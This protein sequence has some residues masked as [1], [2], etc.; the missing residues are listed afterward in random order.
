MTSGKLLARSIPTSRTER[1]KWGTRILL[2]LVSLSFLPAAAQSYTVTDLGTLGGT[3]AIANTVNDAGQV[4]GSS[5]NTGGYIHAYVWTPGKGMQDLGVLRIADDGSFGYGINSVGEV[6]GD[7][8]GSVSGEAAFLWTAAEGMID[9][10]SLGGRSGLAHAVNDSEQVVGESLLGDMSSYHAFL[11]TRAGG[12][13][14]L[15]TLGG[16]TSNAVAINN[17]GEVVGYSLLADNVTQHAFYW[18]Q[19]GGMRDLGT[20]GGTTSIAY[21]INDLGQA[22]GSA[23]NASGQTLAFS[24]TA[25][26]GMVALGPMQNAYPLAINISGQVTGQWGPYPSIGFFWSKST[27]FQNLNNEISHKYGSLRWGNGI[28]KSGAIAGFSTKYRALLL[29]P[30]K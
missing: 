1:E 13:Q 7:S 22:V 24:W 16:Q 3:W 4:V 25:A 2:A 27:G 18:T 10:G 8:Y 12:M 30:N 19:S 9:L 21:A 20:L 26:H 14:D 23:S 6:V 29:T 11:W 5:T 28:N 17:R 15:G